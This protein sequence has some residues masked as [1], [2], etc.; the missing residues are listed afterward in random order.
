MMFLLDSPKGPMTQNPQLQLPL[1]VTP[2]GLQT[3]YVLLKVKEGIL[4]RLKLKVSMLPPQDH[5]DFQ[6][7]GV[8]W[9]TQSTPNPTY[10]HSNYQ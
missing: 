4:K 10:V 9:C 8:F 3:L 7:Q 6:D 2:Q 5:F 1:S